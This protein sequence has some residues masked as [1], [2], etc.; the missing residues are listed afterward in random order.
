MNLNSIGTITRIVFIAIGLVA[1]WYAS[2]SAVY[3]LI[4]VL[5]GLEFSFIISVLLFGVVMIL[6]MF[7]PKNVFI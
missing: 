6:R 5:F 7:Y 1:I 2:I 3:F 4:S